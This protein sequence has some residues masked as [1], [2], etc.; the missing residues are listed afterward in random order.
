MNSGKMYK[1]FVVDSSDSGTA[2]AVK[3]LNHSD[4]PEGNVTVR[5][6]WSSLNYKDG[7]AITGKTPILKIYLIFLK[8]INAFFVRTIINNIISFKCNAECFFKCR[9]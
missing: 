4:L 8:N 7:L 3:E 6:L 1:A 5:I 9:Y 2:G